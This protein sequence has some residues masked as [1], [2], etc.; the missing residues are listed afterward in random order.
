MRRKVTGVASIM[1]YGDEEGSNVTNYFEKSYSSFNWS[2]ETYPYGVSEF[3]IFLSIAASEYETFEAASGFKRS[4]IPRPDDVP[5]CVLQGCVDLLYIP[6]TNI[7][8]S[9]LR[10]DY[11]PCSW[12]SSYTGS[13]NIIENYTANKVSP[14]IFMP[15]MGA[16]PAGP[17]LDTK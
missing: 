17:N 7:F 3:D 1:V 8:T 11:F 15:A 10:K 4:C 5:S 12:K 14:M 16:F 2:T 9:S 6:L 13:K